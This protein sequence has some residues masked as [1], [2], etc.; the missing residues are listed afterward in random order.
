[1]ISRQ[2]VVRRPGW[3]P[4]R[5]WVRR[6]WPG[7]E[8]KSHVWS[9]RSRSRAALQW[10]LGSEWARRLRLGALA[11]VC[12]VSLALGLWCGV[13]WGVRAAKSHRYFALTKIEIEG[14]RRLDRRE[15]LQWAGVSEGSS[16]WDAAPGD[17]RMRLLSH[18]WIQFAQ[19]Q[20]E[21]PDR[22]LIAMQE[23]RPVAIVLSDGPQY[24]DR[25]G[26]VLGPL[27]DD[28]SR[29]FPII[30]GLDG[31]EA[32][33]FTG[34]GM[35]RALQLLRWCER[36]NSFDAVSEIHV[37]RRRGVTVFPRSTAVAVVLGWGSWREK[38]ARSAR[39]FAAW[40]GQVD[41]LAAVDLSFRDLV[42]VKLREEH[43]P[44]AVRPP[45]RGTRV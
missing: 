33:D 7:H 45:K 13:P 3:W 20:R 25:H 19:V 15:V 37:D 31:A 41:R 24:V 29:D 1:V 34:I 26:R 12:G 21:F 40:A 6:V 11:A 30:S 22:L 32:T 8:P 23:R 16:A 38:L 17:V 36:L 43:R 18:P 2:R 35:H 42:V 14:N 28:D 9:R 4:P 5:V 27:R 39:V 44:T 10:A